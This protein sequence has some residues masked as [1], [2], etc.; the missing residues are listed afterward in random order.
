M[1]PRDTFA[2]SF[3]FSFRT[4]TC[5]TA[6]NFDSASDLR[7]DVYPGE[8]SESHSS[9]KAYSKTWR[10]FSSSSFFSHGHFAEN[11]SSLR[12]VSYLQRSRMFFHYGSGEN[13]NCWWNCHFGDCT[14]NGHFFFLKQRYW[15]SVWFLIQH[16]FYCVEAPRINLI[17]SF[18]L[19]WFV[20]VAVTLSTWTLTAE[21]C[22]NTNE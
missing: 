8:L 7:K 11:D 6:S 3:H 14:D 13:F 22:E 21:L 5:G 1:N 9:S 18:G 4:L 2:K 20:S 10:Q 19:N 15:L 16:E 12:G 17:F